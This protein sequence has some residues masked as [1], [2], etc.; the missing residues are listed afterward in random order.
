MALMFNYRDCATKIKACDWIVVARAYL[1]H[2]LGCT[3]FANKSVTHVYVLFLDALRDL[4]QNESYAWGTTALL[5]MYDNLNNASKSM[6]RQLVGYITMLQCW[7]YEHVSSVGVVVPVE[8]YNEKRPRACRW[9]PDKALPVNTYRRRLDKLTP[10]VVCWISYGDH[11]SFREFEVIS[12]FFGHLR[13]GPLTII[14]RPERIFSE[15]I[16]PVE[17]LCAVPDQ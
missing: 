7:I 6:T 4:T 1:L 5:H 9:T 16:P 17:Q 12:L 13:W 8:D 2:L 10:D 3:L 15:Y 14:H 11:C